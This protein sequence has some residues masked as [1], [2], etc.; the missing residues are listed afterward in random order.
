MQFWYSEHHA[1]GVKLS[2]QVEKQLY[3][4]ESAFQRIDVFESMELGRFLTLDGFMMVAEKDEFIYHEMMAHVPMAVFPGV[5]RVLV[6]G[7][8][9]GGVV[10]ELTRYGGIAS[11]DLVEIDP[12]VIDVCKE[13]LPAMA[14]GFADK[15]VR[16]FHQDGAA[17]VKKE[18][19]V[20]DLIIVD[21]TDP[22]GPGAQLFTSEFFQDCYHA[23]TGQ[24]MMIN[25]HETPFYEKEALIV[26]QMHGRMSGIFPIAEVYQAHIPTYASG[27]WLFGFSSKQWH[28]VKNFNAASWDA[29]NVKTQYYNTALH[30]G[31]FALPNYVLDLLKSGEVRQN[32]NH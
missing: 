4:A 8:G 26:Q 14:C 12:M 32:E 7:A 20:Y 2:F 29:L 5:K 10:R 28:P 9:D 23:L 3:S 13:Y 25:Q 24:G 22:I 31:A 15:R 1:P 30:V 18:R 11:I 16:V 27:H 6:V 21:S 17:F 19:G